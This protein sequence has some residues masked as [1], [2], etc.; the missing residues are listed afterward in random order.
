MK[1]FRMVACLLPLLLSAC[2]HSTVQS[3]MQPMAPPIE[4]MPAPPPDSPPTA[5]P[6]PAIAIPKTETPVVVQEQPKPA[7]RHHKPKVPT[8]TAGTTTPGQ[9]AP[10]AA[11]APP[12]E[13]SAI[14][15]ISPTEPANNRKEVEDSIAEVEKGLTGI[16]RPLNA[17]EEKT[18]SQIK[19]FLKQAR[20]ALASGD[21]VGATNL[22]KKAKALLG[23]LSQ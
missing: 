23:E 4:D 3:Q 15:Q 6:S 14:E 12:S 19:E 13:V 8:P 2:N 16:G 21:S 10:V 11:E 20:T 22:T 5:L 7:P 17:T 18:S 1:S 9:P